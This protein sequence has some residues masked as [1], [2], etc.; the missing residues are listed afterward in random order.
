METGYGL[1]LGEQMNL[2]TVLGEAIYKG[3]ASY[4]VAG[5]YWYTAIRGFCKALQQHN[6]VMFLA[7][8]KARLAVDT[9]R[10][11]LPD[12]CYKEALLHV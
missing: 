1:S 11:N 9:C 8:G 6:A 2:N 10:L 12:L 5:G 3:V 4:R 7:K